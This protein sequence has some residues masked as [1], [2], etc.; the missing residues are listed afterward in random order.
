MVA[1]T[2]SAKGLGLKIGTLEMS[3]WAYLG[4]RF[5]SPQKSV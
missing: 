3:K 5:A 1:I 4:P 2:V